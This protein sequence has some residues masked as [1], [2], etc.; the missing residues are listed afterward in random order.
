MVW[1]QDGEERRSIEVRP[2]CI[3]L[4][5]TRG[6]HARLNTTQVMYKNESEGADESSGNRP[7]RVEWRK[8]PNRHTETA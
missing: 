5:E 6:K 4:T 7:T 2:R 3:K 8:P 1:A